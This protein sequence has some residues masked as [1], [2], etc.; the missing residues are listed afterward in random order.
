[1]NNV[2]TEQAP[3]R[4]AIVREVTPNNI[5]PVRPYFNHLVRHSFKR[6]LIGAAAVG[7]LTAVSFRLLDLSLGTASPLYLLVVVLQSLT[8]D[9]FSSAVVSVLAAGCLDYFFVPP[10]FSFEVTGPL[11][12][13]ALISFLVTSLVITKLVSRIRMEARVSELQKDRIDR[14][15]H[16]AQQLLALEPEMAVGERLLQPFAGVFGTRAVCIFDAERGELHTLGRS[17]SHLP[18]RTRAA[19]TQEKDSDDPASQVCVRQL[20]VGGKTTGAMGFEGLED[21]ELTAGPLISLAA[22]SQERTRA[23]QRASESA[24][25]AQT[26]VY[27]SAILDAL[28]HEFKTPLA[29]ILAA[30]GGIRETGSLRAEQLEMTETVESEAARLGSLTSRL[31]RVARLDREEVRPQMEVTDIAGVVSDIVDQYKRLPSDRRITYTRQGESVEAQADPELLRLALNQLLDNACKYSLPGSEITVAMESQPDKIFI[32]VANSGSSIPT[33]EQ[34][35]IFDR[36][37]R[38]EEARRFTSGSGLGLYVARKIALAHGG[39]LELDIEHLNEGVTFY[40][41]LPRAKSESET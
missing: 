16:L 13:A 14:L 15:Y 6:I 32:R 19:F 39:Q 11:N 20:R 8:G 25:A 35:R 23:F 12:V 30:A 2:H 36:F 9:F 29:T 21:P 7:V 31:L 41:A 17:R 27:R 33:S 22:A 4:A 18:E 3:R 37:Y 5:Q 34:Q 10:L 40:L 28:A 1:V 24:A 38:G 26:E